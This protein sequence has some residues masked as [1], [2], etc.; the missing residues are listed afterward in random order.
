MLNSAGASILPRY[1]EDEF[2][3]IMDIFDSVVHHY[4][5]VSSPGGTNF[6]LFQEVKSPIEDK[7]DAKP[8]E[9]AS[10]DLVYWEEQMVVRNGRP[11]ICAL[12]VSSPTCLQS[13]LLIGTLKVQGNDGV[14]CELYILFRQREVSPVRKPLRTNGRSN[15]KLS[16]LRN[17]RYFARGLLND[18]LPR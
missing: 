5:S 17:E 15:A 7:L 11:I 3:G 18:F 8:M 16:G 9:P 1:N 4:R 10:L 12:R 14:D 2:E 6:R 13:C